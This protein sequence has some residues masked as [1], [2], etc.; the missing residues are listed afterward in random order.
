MPTISRAHMSDEL[1]RL[2]AAFL[3][4]ETD[5]INEIAR[6][7]AGGLVDYHAEAALERV[8]AILR[9][10]ENE[11]WE[12]VPQMIERQFYIQH[13]EAR[14][15]Y[16]TIKKHSAG[17]E[18]AQALT[19][20]QTDIIQ[21]LTMNL[22]GEITE[23]TA[24]VGASFEALL[25]GRTTPDIFRRVGLEQVT[26]MEAT[27][28]GAFKMTR[29]FIEALRREGVTAFIDRAGR[30][31]SLHTYGS[32][33]LRT[34]SRQAEV[35]AT[36]TKDPA[37][38]LYKISSHSTTC[39]LCA[40]YEGRVYSRSGTD[41][42]FPPLAD[43]FG[44]ID[45]AGPETLSNTYLNIHPNCLV[46]GGSIL[47]EGVMAHTSREYSGPVI[48]LET[49]RGNRITVTPNHPILTTTGF[50]PAATLQK[51]QKIVEATGEY[52]ILLGEA[53]DN[54]NIPTPVED[55]SH[56]IIQSGGSATVRMESTSKQFHGDGVPHS[57]VEI[58]FSK[59]FVESKLNSLGSEPVSKKRLPSGHFWRIQLF[60]K[61]PL[62]QI[63]QG[64][65]CAAHC[66]MCR[67]G[68][69]GSVKT[70]SVESKKTTNVCERTT[71]LLGNLCKC[72][73]IVVKFKKPFKLFSTG[74][75]ISWRHIKK[76]FSLFP[77][78]KSIVNHG[79]FDGVLCYPEMLRNLRI[80]EPL[81]AQRLQDLFRDNAL[82]ISNLV[83]VETSEYHG[84]VYN[85][86]TKYGFYTYNNIVT[87]NCL[88]VLLPW[89]PAG[90]TPEEIKEAEN[91]SN[92][93]KNPYSVD[94]RSQKQIDA[95]RKK[96]TARRQWL[97]TYRQWEDYR[98]AIPEATPKTFATFQKHKLAG[99]DKYKKW[100][101]K[102][103]EV[104][105][106][107][108]TQGRSSP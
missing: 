99:D 66:I 107:G 42:V 106:H 85:L 76:L 4:A 39:A 95:Y 74:F 58:V 108:E 32:M 48:T 8:Q 104:T 67:L 12:Y 23:A 13:P 10:L 105:Q 5:I 9:S 33:V 73:P 46:P 62:L 88:H 84:M 78:K 57:K 72:K 22:M 20:A 51:G 45:P 27:G 43:A 64:P 81:A 70:V 19:A 60:P 53:P 97:E 14:K 102:Y 92:P 49:S 24:T 96:E 18:N 35:L 55:I 3:K 75:N 94:P 98:L 86:E 15:L 82:V 101:K 29:Q 38:D 31:W 44:K 59:G 37:Q 41:P 69:C 36:L 61:S 90:R 1:E 21:R 40:P 89:T 54:I 65:R 34:T 103:R 56:S 25:I 100:V 30:R 28:Q 91:F 11:S 83:H 26:A 63:L 2:I 80:S 17:Y 47:A 16:E 77:L 6:L 68:F 52:R 93:K 79:S 7:R 87:H 71:T 50:V